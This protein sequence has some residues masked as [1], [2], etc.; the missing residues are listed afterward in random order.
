MPFNYNSEWEEQA[1]APSTPASGNWKIYPK[2]DGFYA[3]DD[4]GNEYGPFSSESV[5]L[6]TAATELTISA[7]SV[8]ATQS[9]HTIDTQSDAASDDLDTISGG[10]DGE[11]LYIRPEHTDRTVV[12]KHGTGN[13]YTATGNDISMESTSHYVLLIYDSTVGGWIVLTENTPVDGDH[14]ATVAD[15]DTTPGITVVY[16]IDISGHTG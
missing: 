15:D 6:L 1:S 13:I 7:G 12:L 16:P 8:T 2:S 14:V 11:L 10:T 9:H 4:A 5:A 3:I